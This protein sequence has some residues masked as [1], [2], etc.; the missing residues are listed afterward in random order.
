MRNDRAA[1]ALIA[2][3]RLIHEEAQESF[4]RKHFHR[5]VRKCQEAVELALKGYL[6]L[7]GADYPK[8]HDVAPA[9]KEVARNKGLA[10]EAELSE[11]SRV[12]ARLRADRERS[13]YGGEDG[14][15]PDELFDATKAQRALDD[16][17]SVLTFV[18]K[19]CGQGK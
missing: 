3:A 2:N 14:V 18:A 7:L 8:V 9:L 15:P 16:C 6:L 10:S 1:Q 13:F 11:L 4:T 19:H 5:T 12:S 17:A